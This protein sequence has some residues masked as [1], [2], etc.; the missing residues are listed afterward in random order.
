MS[1][2]SALAALALLA[3]LGAAGG[4]RA[5]E[6]D[7]VLPDAKLEARAR[8]VSSGL[9]CLVCQNQSI[10]DSA[11]PLARDLR[12]IVREHLKAGDTDAEIR[13]YLVQRYG[14]FVLLKP[15]FEPATLLL[16]GTPVL[17]VGLG[18]L[19]LLRRPRPSD[20]PRPLTPD[21]QARVDALM[22]EPPRG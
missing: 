18:G 7:E 22:A 9:R 1:A 17:V 8:E 6:P 12:L 4:A 14:D 19:A 20:A 15:P 21:E 10:D 5:V 3:G 11:A 13:A 16:W 2:R